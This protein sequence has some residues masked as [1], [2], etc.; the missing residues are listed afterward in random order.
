MDGTILSQGV[1]TSQGPN[2]G[3]DSVVSGN[4][5]IVQIPSNADWMYVRNYTQLGN[6]GTPT[7]NVGLE[8]YWQRGMAPGTG[9]VYYGANGVETLSADTLLTG[10]FTLYDP[11]GSS[12]SNAAPLVGPAV[13]TTATTNVQRPVVSTG[14][15]AGLAVGSVVRLSNNGGANTSVYGVDMVVSAITANTNFT[16]LFAA[17][18][19]ANNPGAAGTAGFWRVVNV[20]SPFYPRKRYIT[21]ITQAVNPTVS[22][23]V[24]HGLTPGQAI[25]FNIPAVSGMI[26]LNST[27]ANNYQ[28]ATVLTVIDDYD[29]TIDINTTN[30]TAFTFPT[31]AQ[32]PSS[33]PE[34]TPVGENT[35]Q[36]LILPGSQVPSVGGNQ[37]PNTNTGILADSTTNTLF[38]GMILGPGGNGKKVGALI[39]G[40]SGAVTN[41]GDVLSF[42][43]LYWTAGKS[44]YGGL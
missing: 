25:R 28:V 23:S 19:L 27:P 40:P 24:A 12:G 42:D 26:Q 16:L 3:T 20:D 29:F 5:I 35:A 6:I 14:S 2:A 22:T 33:Y 36:A 43:T 15:T 11:S 37:I 32:Q 1:I 13:A 31:V 17:N 44:S 10:G 9:I 8:F 34:M 39:I 18:Q 30:F 21:N 7:P 41:A 4:S 38:L